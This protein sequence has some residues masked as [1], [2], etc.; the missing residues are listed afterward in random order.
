VALANQ[1]GG[2]SGTLKLAAARLLGNEAITSV[3]FVTNATAA[4]GPTH[5]WAALLDASL[6]VVRQSTD[7]LTAAINANSAVTYTLDSIPATAGSRSGGTLVTLTIPTL[8]DSLTN[9]VA[10]NDSVTVS[11]ASTAAYNGTFT[12]VGVTSTT[13]TY[14]AASSGTDSLV[15]PFPTVQLAASKRTF[16]PAAP[17]LYYFGWLVAVST[18]MPTF[19]GAT[20]QTAAV[21]LSPPVNGTSSAS[22]TGTCPSP[23]ANLTATG[24]IPYFYWS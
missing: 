18:T 22:L 12:V 19:T 10:V 8:H 15:A 1:A 7:Q 16:T 6:N 23:A 24:A 4:T 3:T 17:A 11:N 20:T 5:A 9:L 13:I 2:T 14:N 21:S